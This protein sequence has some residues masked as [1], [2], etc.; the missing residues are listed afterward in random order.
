MQIDRFIW[1]AEVE[2]KI[3]RKHGVQP[4]EAEEV[5]FNQPLFRFMERGQRVGEDVYAVH[6]QTEAGRYVTVIFIHKKQ[7]NALVIT[8]RDMTDRERRLYAKHI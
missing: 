4:H 1:L 2:E 7:G 8:A 5:F 3:I 6:G